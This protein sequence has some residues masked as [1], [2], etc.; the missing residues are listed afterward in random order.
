MIDLYIFLIYI[1]GLVATFVLGF[2][3]NKKIKKR[4]KKFDLWFILLLS[5]LSYIGVLS[6]IEIWFTCYYHKEYDTTDS[7]IP[8]QTETKQ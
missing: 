3:L 7:N 1:S 6:L 8:N 2:A 5:L 4:Y